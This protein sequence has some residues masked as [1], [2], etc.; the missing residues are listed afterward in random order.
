MNKIYF[1]LLITAVYTSCIKTA[2]LDYRKPV[3]AL[4]VDGVLL[5][6]T[7]PCT[8][9]LSYSGL[10]N[11]EGAQQQNFIDDAVVYLKDDAGD[12]SKLYA[13]GSGQYQSAGN[14]NAVVG[15]SYSLSIAL[16][17]GKRYAS[18]PEKITP[19]SKN[20]EL[21]SISSTTSYAWDDL[22]GGQMKIRTKD[23]ADQ[24]NYYRWISTDWLS[25]EATGIPCGANPCF[26]YCYQY[27]HDPTIYVLPD[28]F[29]NGQEIR[30]ETA[31]TSPYFTVGK[32]Y[33]ELKQLSLTQNAYQFWNLYQQQTTRTGGILDP[34]PSPIQGN[35]YNVNDSKELALGYFEASDVTSIKFVFAPLFVNT[36]FTF[37]NR[38]N[39][40]AVGACY[41]VYPNA[42]NDPPP[43]WEGAP[44][45]IVNVY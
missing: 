18:V 10:F 31:L 42:L 41:L 34:L 23:P 2:T 16:S 28:K 11:S 9:T 43:G 32:H 4:V 3:P 21:D 36:Y 17:N 7:T 14:V 6:D 24:V 13:I 25:R 5:T 22:Y 15:R 33:I 44:E 8:I 1:I 26:V 27:Y 40:I 30:Y 37:R 29:V 12:S 20:F 35:I 39:H 38:P 45:Y 19:V